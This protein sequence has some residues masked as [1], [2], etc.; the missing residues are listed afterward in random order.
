MVK[1][2][3]SLPRAS[4]ISQKSRAA[5]S[6]CEPSL[7]DGSLA[8][9]SGHRRMC[10]A[11]S[12][13]LRVLHQNLDPRV[14]YLSPPERSDCESRRSDA[15]HVYSR[16]YES[17]T[18]SFTSRPRNHALSQAYPYHL[19]VFTTL[20]SSLTDFSWMIPGLDAEP[21]SVRA[22]SLLFSSEMHTRHVKLCHRHNAMLVIILERGLSWTSGRVR[23]C[24]G[25][26]IEI[27]SRAY[28]RLAGG[29]VHKADWP[30]PTASP[31]FS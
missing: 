1:W 21:G 26:T 25:R 18:L 8:H 31:S 2:L 19:G 10:L 14:S 11:L 12:G 9:K 30:R 23:E 22:M 29:A 17:M 7:G 5:P 28:P 6:C 13:R 3:P 27:R 4:A 15:G 16:G 24:E 20:Y